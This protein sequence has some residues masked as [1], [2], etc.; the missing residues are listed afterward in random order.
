MDNINTRG[1]YVV[2]NDQRKMDYN[3]SE[4]LKTLRT[5]LRFAGEDIKLILFTS[6]FP[7]EGKSDI[8]I[9]LAKE[10]GGIG[11][12]TLFLDT[13]IRKSALLSRFKVENRENIHGLSEYLSGQV[14][15]R[16]L[17][18]KT[19]FPNM[20]LICAGPSAPDPSGMLEGKKFVSLLQATKDIYD[21]VII[22]TPP[23]ET[24]IDA[25]VVAKHAD[26]AI[27]IIEADAVSYRDAQRAQRQIEMSGC[28]I[29]G[30]V[31]NKV[32]TSSDRYYNK[33]SRY[34]K[35]SKYGKYAKYGGYYRKPAEESESK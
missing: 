13:D 12:K 19:N 8:A 31:L 1:N 21:F 25:A 4:A 6:C 32:D 23:I 20:D 35:Y 34:G 27:M 14:D 29:L 2:L 16:G 17:I 9:S 10:L 5:N 15:L 22:D 7:N 24:V 33:Y 28:R 11:K 18:Y 3:Y 26:G 30:A